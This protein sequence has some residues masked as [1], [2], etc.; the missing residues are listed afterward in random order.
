MYFIF[1]LPSKILMM[2]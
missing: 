1:L 2:I